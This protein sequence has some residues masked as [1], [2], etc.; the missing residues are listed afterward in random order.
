MPFAAGQELARRIPDAR[1]VVH[2]G[3]GHAIIFER[4]DEGREHVE[5]FLAGVEGRAA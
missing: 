3:A 1:F 2:E 5:A 4:P